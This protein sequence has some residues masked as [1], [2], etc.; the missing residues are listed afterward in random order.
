MP[1]QDQIQQALEDL[2]LINNALHIVNQAT[3]HVN[4]QEDFDAAM[5]KGFAA[6][7]EIEE[8]R[9]GIDL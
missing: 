4:S 2:A 1:P 7:E 8:R 9:G 6:L 3:T 5:Q